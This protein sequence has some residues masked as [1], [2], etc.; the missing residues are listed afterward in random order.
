MVQALQGPLPSCT[1]TGRETAQALQGRLARVSEGDEPVQASK[2]HRLAHAPVLLELEE[3]APLEGDACAGGV[4]LDRSPKWNEKMPPSKQSRRRQASRPVVRRGANNHR[5]REFSVPELRM[6]CR[7]L[8]GPKRSLSAAEFDKLEVRVRNGV[9]FAD[10]DDKWHQS[11]RWDLMK[12]QGMARDADDRSRAMSLLK[13]M[14]KKVLA[15]PKAVKAQET[16][17]MYMDTVML[18]D[19]PNSRFAEMGATASRPRST[20]GARRSPMVARLPSRPHTR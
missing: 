3:E 10:S 12:L 2:G 8:E 1:L 15:N 17:G 18:L 13:L 7:Q 5:A 19:N 9:S 11:L 20:A 4:L 16:V 6:A 14:H